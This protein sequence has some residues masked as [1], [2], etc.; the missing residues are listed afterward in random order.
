MKF[1][2]IFKT[3]TRN[4]KSDSFS[5]KPKSR[6]PRDP[7]NLALL[8]WRFCLD[9]RF[10]RF[11][12]V[13]PSNPSDQ[14]PHGQ[15]SFGIGKEN[16]AGSRTAITPALQDREVLHA[17]ECARRVATRKRRQRRRNTTFH[18]L[19]LRMLRP[20]YGKFER[21]G[22]DPGVDSEKRDTLRLPRSLNR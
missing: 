2:S 4:P 9:L 21:T 8:H 10:G 14:S 1:E 18:G 19:R 6:L 7:K 12:F 15:L 3:E 17:L 16:L 5:C 13:D 22:N 11:A 20:R